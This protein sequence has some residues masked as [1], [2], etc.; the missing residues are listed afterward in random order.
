M[1]YSPAMSVLLTVLFTLTGLAGIYRSIFAL[2]PIDRT[3]N[4]V[5]LVMSFAM[6][7]MPWSWGLQIFPAGWQ[8]VVFSV[9][10]AFYLIL[11]IIRPHAVAG[12][13]AGHHSRPSLL[14]YHAL[15]MGS[16]VV[17]GVMMRDMGGMSDASDRNP[18]KGMDGMTKTAGNSGGMS[19]QTSTWETVT[20]VMLGIGFGLAA[21]W[22]LADLA[23]GLGESD[24]R[25]TF[26]TSVSALM[27]IGMSVAFF[28][29]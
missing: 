10:A 29:I 22:F 3:S 9:A 6:L 23:R 1:S 24:R 28:A 19:M 15:M 7:S 2:D 8:I 20:S 27:A 25:R 5:H 26:D 21:L 14:G 16:M 18:M 12:P 4:I 13:A 11:L 17:M